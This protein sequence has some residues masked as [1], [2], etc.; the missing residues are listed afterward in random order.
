MTSTQPMCLRENQLDNRL[1]ELMSKRVLDDST[2]LET[3]S[4][5]AI[6]LVLAAS[7]PDALRAQVATAYRELCN[8]STTP[9]M[10]V[11]GRSSAT[12]E[13]LPS[14]SFA[15]AHESFLNVVGVDAVLGC[16][17]RCYASLYT[18]RAIRYREDMG[19][20]HDGV[21]L[22]VGFRRW[23]PVHRPCRV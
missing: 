1:Q 9:N 14:A 23:S 10:E 12:A 17:R 13:D 18:P 15:R 21:A 20:A 6:S 2:A 4:A 19:F 11:A 3:A 22:S 5:E 16:V 8:R 7:L